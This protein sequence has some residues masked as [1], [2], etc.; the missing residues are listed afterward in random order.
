MSREL[1]NK[2]YTAGFEP[3]IIIA[4]GRGGF[5]PARIVSD[6]LLFRD[7]TTIKIEHWGV[8]ATLD[9]QAHIRFGLSTDISGIKVLVVDDITDTGDTLIEAVKYINEQGPAE[10]RTAVLQHKTCS[11]YVPDFFVHRI[12]KWRWIIYPWA[13]FEDLSGFVERILGDRWI[14]T[15]DVQQRLMEN[16]QLSVSIKDLSGILEQMVRSG[17]IQLKQT[18][19]GSNW[20][21]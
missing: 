3:D 13:V 21:K 4:I 17:M 2:I 15:G 10:V 9:K 6:Y 19:D 18:E 20:K 7:L 12:V 1:A 8:A 11:S 14:T 16:F 5:V